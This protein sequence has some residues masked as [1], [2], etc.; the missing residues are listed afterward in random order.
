[1]HQLISDLADW[2]THLLQTWGA[3]AI[4]LMMAIESTVVPIP[5]EVVIPRPR[6]W[7]TPTRFH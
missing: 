3:P 4:A 5:S 6:I 2:Y 7:H 1:M